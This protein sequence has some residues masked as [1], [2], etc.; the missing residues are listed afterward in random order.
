MPIIAGH[1]VSAWAVLTSSRWRRILQACFQDAMVWLLARVDFR[2]RYSPYEQIGHPDHLADYKRSA[3]RTLRNCDPPV[4]LGGGG[5]PMRRGAPLN[6][7]RPIV[8]M[9]IRGSS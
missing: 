5:R 1:N 4:R 2:P 9:A 8:A 7:S 3:C 6:Q